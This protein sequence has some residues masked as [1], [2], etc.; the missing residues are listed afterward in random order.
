M[1]MIHAT[2]EQ[3]AA[4]KNRH[5]TS[6]TVAWI[7]V[8]GVNVE[9]GPVCPATSPAITRSSAP[10]SAVLSRVASP[11]RRSW[12]LGS[13][14]LSARGRFTHSCRPWNSPPLATRCSG[15]RSMCS[16]PPPAVIH[17]VSPFVIT[18]PPPCESWCSKMPSMM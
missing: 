10:P 14:H 2:V 15:G 12:Y 16:S 1:T 13:S 6:S 7:M 5:V 11:A 9:P 4:T 8:I 18:P 3:Y 17:W